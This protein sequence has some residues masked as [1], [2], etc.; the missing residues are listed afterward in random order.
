MKVHFAK[1]TH[2]STNREM[3]YKTKG[4]KRTYEHHITS[5]AYT[6]MKW[7]DIKNYKERKKVH[8]TRIRET[9][10]RRSTVGQQ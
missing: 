8:L 10:E 2:I 1:E 5:Y 6:Y 7:M 4:V 9:I 3:E